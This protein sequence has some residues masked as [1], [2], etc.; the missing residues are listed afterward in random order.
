[1]LL[2]EKRVGRQHITGPGGVQCI[3]INMQLT[4]TITELPTPQGSHA[5]TSGITT[6]TVRVGKNEGLERTPKD[7]PHSAGPA[8]GDSSRLATQ[9]DPLGVHQ[10]IPALLCGE[11]R[12]R[13]LTTRV[14]GDKA[15]P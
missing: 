14:Q 8:A 11:K 5:L 10:S 2:K 12:W 7:R 6:S 4:V 1:M 13:G 15:D 9:R 3:A